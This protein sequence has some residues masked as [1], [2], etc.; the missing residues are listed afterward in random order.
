MGKSVS[1]VEEAPLP[2]FFR[3]PAGNPCLDRCCGRNQGLELSGVL[4]QDSG[5]VF[6]PVDLREQA[7]SL[8]V[9]VARVVDDESLQKFGGT[10]SDL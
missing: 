10:R 1:E 3:I 6:R 7:D 5:L 4:F 9:I 2:V 8:V